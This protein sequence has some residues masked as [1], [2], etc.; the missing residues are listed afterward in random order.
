MNND[1]VCNRPKAA[2]TIA[3]AGVYDASEDETKSSQ[4]IPST[5][6]QGTNQCQVLAR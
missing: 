5:A 1:E 3:V 6:I 4:C 2:L